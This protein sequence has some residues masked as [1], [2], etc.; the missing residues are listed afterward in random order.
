MKRLTAL[1]LLLSTAILFIA[2]SASTPGANFSA[3]GSINSVQVLRVVDGDTLD[4][5]I[6]GNKHRVR[7]FGVDTP[8]R[9][10]RCY[11]EA[12]DRTLELSGDSVLLEAGP[13]KEDK[14]GRLL[15][16]L[17]TQSGESIDTKLIQEGL[18]TAWTRDGQYRDKLVNEENQARAKGK[19]CLW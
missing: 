6:A 13:R 1:P 8:E 16:Y 5:L 11:Q 15:F 7:L 18:A 10:E 19:G 17:Y 3:P 12:M 14:Y 4:V 9:G 2:C